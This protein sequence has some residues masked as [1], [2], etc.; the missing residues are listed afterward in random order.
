MKIPDHFRKVIVVCDNHG[1]WM[2]EEG[3]EILGLFDFMLHPEAL[4]K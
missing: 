1:G 3:I 2:N 4:E